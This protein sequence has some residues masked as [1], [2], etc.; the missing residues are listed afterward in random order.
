MEEMSKKRVLI[1]EDNAAFLNMLK[2]RLELN[3]YEVVTALDGIE[4]LEM[5]RKAN[6][7]LIILDLALPDMNQTD[8]TEFNASVDKSLGHKVCRMVKYDRKTKSIPVLILTASD[9]AEDENIAHQVGADAFLVKTEPTDRMLEKIR[10]LLHKP[11]Y[12]SNLPNGNAV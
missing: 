5:V 2:I 1:I 9:T 11:K 8:E 12:I 3:G 10:E 7:D 4:G 6:P